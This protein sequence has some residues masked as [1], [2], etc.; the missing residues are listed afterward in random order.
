LLYVS[1]SN[2]NILEFVIDFVPTHKI[3][4]TDR[5]ELGS[6][7]AESNTIRLDGYMHL[8]CNNRPVDL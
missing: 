2:Y 6:Y 4:A 5:T 7:T 8:D 1:I 3:C